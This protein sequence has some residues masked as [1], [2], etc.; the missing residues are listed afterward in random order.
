MHPL[1]DDRIMMNPT[2]ADA[3]YA[4]GMLESSWTWMDHITERIHELS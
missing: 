4:G 1:G 3:G 2:D